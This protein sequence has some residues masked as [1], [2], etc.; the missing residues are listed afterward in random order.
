MFH[1]RDSRSVAAMIG[2]VSFE[3]ISDAV[4]QIFQSSISAGSKAPLQ[5]DT[6]LER[7]RIFEVPLPRHL[8]LDH[9]AAFLMDSHIAAAMRDID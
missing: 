2:R 1:L 9:G 4:V 3:L 6:V 8:A 5:P 7:L